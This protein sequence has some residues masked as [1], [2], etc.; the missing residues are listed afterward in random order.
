VSGREHYRQVRDWRS[1]NIDVFAADL[2][3]SELVLALADDAQSVIGCYNTTLQS[4]LDKDVPSQL[5]R[6]RTRQS[7][8]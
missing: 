1:L 6:V 8:L 3:C 5:K 2:Q 4:L 7:S